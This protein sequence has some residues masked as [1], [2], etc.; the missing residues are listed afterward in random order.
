MEETNPENKAIAQPEAAAEA[1]QQSP[2]PTI[3]SWSVRGVS[4]LIVLSLI[5]YFS[6]AAI[7]P[8]QP[9]SITFEV[10]ENKIE[11]R[12]ATWM[13]PVDITNEGTVSIRSL[14]VGVTFPDPL[15]SGLPREQEK[16]VMIRLLGAKE[17][18]ATTFAFTADPRTATPEFF[19]VS[20]VRP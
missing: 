14:T 18:V 4:L 20:Y 11:R 6:W 17:T 16:T 19:V 13:M 7:R 5:A 15:A 10:K 1:D 3:L 12:G 8:I 9:P 2:P